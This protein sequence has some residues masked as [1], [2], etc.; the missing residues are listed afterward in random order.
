MFVDWRMWLEAAGLPELDAERGP[1]FNHSHLVMQAA[2]SGDGVALGRSA[3]V[4]D[5]LRTGVLV[6]PF[7]ISLPSRYSYF[8]VC[9]KASLADPA[10]AGFR[11]WLV[12]QGS[13]S[14]P[15]LDRLA[16]AH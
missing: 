11:N 7:D 4:A 1:G 9:S 13:A 16:S 14:Q 2:M 8:V 6:K 5:A 12:A 3:L 10:V 15:E